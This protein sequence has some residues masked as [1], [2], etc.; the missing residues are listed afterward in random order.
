VTTLLARIPRPIA[1]LLITLL[2]A[3]GLYAYQATAPSGSPLAPVV[4]DAYPSDNI[5]ICNSSASDYAITAYK[6]DWSWSDVLSPDQCSA[7]VNN[8]GSNPVRVN[9]NSLTESYKLGVVG[10]GYGPCH[11]GS[12]SASNPPNEHQVRY[13]VYDNPGC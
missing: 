2:V 5:S 10:E 6:T 4:A 3:A 9:T 12:N 8:T 11:D 7:S 13:R 1:L